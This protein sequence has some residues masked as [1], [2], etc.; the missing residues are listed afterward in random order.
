MPANFALL[1]S[2]RGVLRQK[3][4]EPDRWTCHQTSVRMVFLNKN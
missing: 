4:L 1:V 3:A 2:A